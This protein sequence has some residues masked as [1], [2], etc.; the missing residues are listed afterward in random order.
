M[1]RPVDAGLTPASAAVLRRAIA[2]LRRDPE[3]DRPQRCELE[4]L[5]KDGSS[6]WTE[7]GLSLL[8]DA[9]GIA[10]G[11]LIDSRD[12]TERRRLETTSERLRDEIAHLTRVTTMGELTAALA[13][14]LHQPLTAILNNAHAARR[15]IAAGTP[16]LEE[17]REIVMDIVADD[18]RAGDVIRRVRSLVKKAPPELQSLD[19]ADAVAEVVRLVD[20]D[21]L[22]R[23]IHL[24]VELPPGL[25]RVRGDRI[26]LQ[27]V[28]LNLVV[29]GFDA[30]KDVPG[31]RSL[32]VRAES[33]PGGE[34]VVTVLDSGPGIP[35]D[36]LDAIFTPFFS[37]KPDGLGMGLA[38]CRT[39]VAS[40][41][42]RIWAE[43]AEPRG[44]RVQFSLPVEGAGR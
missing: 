4:R 13:H 36:R 44:A 14:E 39:I 12:I 34:V 17:I 25:P 37:T 27:Q 8:R 1:A 3:V 19:L 2:Q 16:D 28:I 20:S 32:T 22:I 18:Q 42:G 31:E 15:M 30:M 7:S 6:V 33:R 24:N 23:G 26:Q 43:N 21:A 9:S 5:R 10:Q 40:M 38:I 41:G 29:N 35:P 11:V